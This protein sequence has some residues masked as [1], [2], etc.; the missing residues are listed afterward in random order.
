VLV[1]NIKC[2]C[3][4]VVPTQM[5]SAAQSLELKQE[6]GHMGLAPVQAL[7]TPHAVPR[8]LSVLGGQTMLAPVQKA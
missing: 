2:A 4:Q 7:A 8:G 3:T 5:A 6:A 1:T